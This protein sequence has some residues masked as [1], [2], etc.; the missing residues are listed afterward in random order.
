MK[1]FITGGTGF[2]GRDLSARLSAE[3]HQVT[4]LTRGASRSRTDALRFI[5]GDPTHPGPWQEE[6]AQHD[7]LINL[8]GTSIFGR[9][10]PEYKR[11]LRESRILTT[12]HLVEAMPSGGKFTLISTS[13]VGYY[14]F[15]ADEALDESSSPGKDFLATLSV[16]WE[17]EAMKAA[18]KGARVV[19]TRFGIV[20]G[21]DGGALDQMLTPFRWFV[22]GPIGS[23]RQWFSWIHMQ[24]L[25]GAFVHLLAHPELSGPFNFTAP[26]PV[27]NGE[28]AKAL[29][30]VLGRPSWMPAPAFMLKLVLGEFGSVILEGQRVLPRR[31]LESGFSFRF[32]G[33]E[34]ALRDLLTS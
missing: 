13:A 15:H 2:V 31:L 19:V 11:R 21:R 20:L 34:E 29:G 17:A 10:S 16:D 30:K 12:R 5:Q 1:I 18:D 33:I 32:S 6:A 25:V 23:G 27:R 7:V 3:G 22:G 14:G 4:V 24:D 8:A 9:W 28:L 26:N